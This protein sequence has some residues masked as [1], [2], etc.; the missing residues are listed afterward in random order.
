MSPENEEEAKEY[1][2]LNTS[3]SE[4]DYI[5]VKVSYWKLLKKNRDYRFFLTSYLITHGGEWLTYI[6]SIDF[7]ERSQVERGDTTLSRTSISVLVLVRLLPNVLFSGFG[8]TLADAYDRRKLMTVLDVAGAICALFFVLACQLN[9]ISLIYLATFLQQS[10]AGLYEPSSSS[11][12]PLLVRNEQDLQK[13]TILAGLVWS[14]ITAFGAAASGFIVD[15]LG[16]R[17]CFS[18]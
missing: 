1:G 14:A 10:V 15:A 6:A 5:D 13:A 12:V 8:G 7:I 2:T 9:S 11:I 18:T 3:L 17:T 4:T 16:S